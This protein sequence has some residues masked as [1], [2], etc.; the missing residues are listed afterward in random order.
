MCGPGNFTE[1]SLNCTSCPSGKYQPS[2]AQVSC[3]ACPAGKFARGIGA[4]ECAVS[5]TPGPTATWGLDLAEHVASAADGAVIRLGASTYEWK[6]QVTCGGDG[7]DGKTITLIGVGKG[8]TVL[9]ARG[10]AY[11]FFW[12]YGPCKLTLSA[13]SLVNGGAGAL[14]LWGGASVSATNVEFKNNEAVVRAPLPAALPCCACA[15]LVDAPAYPSS[16]LFALFQS[17]HGGVAYLWSST[18]TFTSC[19]FTQNRATEVRSRLTRTHR[20]TA[21]CRPQA[22]A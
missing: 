7:K 12:W 9:D 10:G 3:L 11:R 22:L 21:P 19:S 14:Y 13:I 6:R 15:A 17:Q 1:S 18:S 4:A 20:L 5:P 16:P 2:W 8:T